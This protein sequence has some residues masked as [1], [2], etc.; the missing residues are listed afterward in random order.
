MLVMELKFKKN[1][2]KQKQKQ[3]Q[4]QNIKKKEVY[5]PKKQTNT[6][7]Y[8]AYQRGLYTHKLTNTQAHDAYQ[9]GLY[10]HASKRPKNK[11]T[12]T[13]RTGVVAAGGFLTT[14]LSFKHSDPPNLICE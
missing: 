11:Y 5:T 7:A 12:L 4:K 14:S 1:K 10:T 2:T 8:N 6:Q 9:R 3:K 13:M